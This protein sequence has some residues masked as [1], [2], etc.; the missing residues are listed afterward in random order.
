MMD[1]L[2]G[3]A[4]RI[5]QVEGPGPIPMGPWPRLEGNAVRVEIDGP[6]V[7]VIRLPDEQAEVVEPTLPHPDD[8]DRPGAGPGCRRPT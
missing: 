6:T 2:D 8:R 1:D 5:K 4:V 3:V 7:D